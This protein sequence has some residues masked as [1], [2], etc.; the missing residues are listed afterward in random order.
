MFLEF[1]E[2]IGILHLSKVKN[3]FDTTRF[4]QV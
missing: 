3:V 1:D 2:K 4:L